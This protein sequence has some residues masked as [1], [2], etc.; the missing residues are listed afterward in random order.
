MTWEA[1]HFAEDWLDS[2][3]E[4]QGCGFSRYRTN[5]AANSGLTGGLCLE[6]K[7]GGL[8]TPSGIVNLPEDRSKWPP[9]GHSQRQI[10]Q[11]AVLA[12]AKVENT[13]SA[14]NLTIPAQGT[15]SLRLYK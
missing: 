9:F 12:S 15:I 7:R 1:K 11:H 6:M 8:M 4:T 10:H 2:F 14:F 13:L 3:P 5:L